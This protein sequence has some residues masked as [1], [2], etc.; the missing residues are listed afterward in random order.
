MALQ[1]VPSELGPTRVLPRTHADPVAHEHRSEADLRAYLA[2]TPSRLALLRTGD[3]LLYDGRILH[4]GSENVGGEPRVLFYVT[5]RHAADDD[6]TLDLRVSEDAHSILP[7][8]RGTH[9]LGKLLAAQDAQ[10]VQD[11]RD[12][13]HAP[14]AAADDD[15]WRVATM[16]WIRGLVIRHEL[17]PWALPAIN[18]VER[19]GFRLISASPCDASAVVA[20][21]AAALIRSRVPR[22]TTLIVFADA[23][24][25]AGADASLHDPAAFAALY[26]RAI[27][28]MDPDEGVDVLAFHPLRLDSG[29]GC[30]TDPDDAA[31]FSVRS[32]LPTLQLLR[33]DDLEIARSEWCA[34]HR[35]RLPGALQ[36]LH[37]NKARLRALG[38]EAICAMFGEWRQRLALGTRSSM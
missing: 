13:P 6:D 32:P 36:L 17:C 37:D 12:A 29:P 19:G 38:S 8:L 2:T 11:T 24:A 7:E 26:R 16:A 27:S 20:Q 10:D 22:P 34:A 3:A 4:C 25:D 1:D 23:D 33:R 18:N 28:S 14:A 30:S 5:F 9:T 31:H 35:S 21:E 15:G